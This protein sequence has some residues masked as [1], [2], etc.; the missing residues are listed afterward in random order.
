MRYLYYKIYKLLL[1]KQNNNNPVLHT[2]VLL[3]VLQGLNVYSIVDI[4]NY[5]F[6]LDIYSHVPVLFGLLLFVVLLIP[7]YIYIFRKHN[8]IVKRYKN[9]VREDRNWG[10]VGLFLYVLVSIAVFLILGGT[11]K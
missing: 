6:N 9:E 8:E 5:F 1:N 10:F 4:I 7:N 3:V 2:I 11:I